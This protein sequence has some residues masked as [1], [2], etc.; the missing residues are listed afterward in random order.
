VGVLKGVE[1]KAEWEHVELYGQETVFREDIARKDVRVNVN[2]K[3]AK[4]HPE[5]IGLIL[6]TENADEDI[7]GSVESGSTMAEITD[8]NTCPLFDIW[9][10][11]T[12]KNAETYSVKVTNISWDGA[13]WAAPEGDYMVTD[14][15]GVGDKMFIGYKTT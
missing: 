7:D 4:F 14:L 11:V 15:T 5:A 8:T 2:V 10:T 1:I 9:G 3:F 12:G 13:P 6:G